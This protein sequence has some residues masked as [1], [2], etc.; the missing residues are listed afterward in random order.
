M[1]NKTAMI[2]ASLLL[3]LGLG[4]CDKPGPGERAGKKLDEAASDAGKKMDDTAERVDKTVSGQG[5]AMALALDDTEITARVK[6]AI[7]AEPGLR[8]LQISVETHSGIVTLTG[9]VDSPATFDKVA[10]MVLAVKGVKDVRNELVVV[11]GK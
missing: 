3:V 9:S 7:L 4:A 11:S 5:D 2:A 1:I 10:A 8:S 6:A